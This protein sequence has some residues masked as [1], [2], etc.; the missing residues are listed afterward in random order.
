M[1]STAAGRSGRDREIPVSPRTAEQSDDLCMRSLRMNYFVAAA[2]VTLA[3]LLKIVLIEVE[4][5]GS[6]A[7][8]ATA[9]KP[10][11]R[12]YSTIS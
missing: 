1:G 10:A 12:A 5:A 6:V 4:M 2:L 8:A 3:I 7:P 9:M 11:S